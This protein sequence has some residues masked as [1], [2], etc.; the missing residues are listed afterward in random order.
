MSRKTS[1]LQAWAV[2]IVVAVGQEGAAGE[3]MSKTSAGVS[4]GLSFDPMAR[5]DPTK[6]AIL[7]FLEVR[8]EKRTEVGFVHMEGVNRLGQA[9]GISAKVTARCLGFGG[10]QGPTGDYDPPGWA[11][12][13][14]M[15]RLTLFPYRMGGYG[16]YRQG[17]VA[18]YR[19]TVVPKFEAVV[20]RL[21]A[22]MKDG[23]AVEF[24][25]TPVY[26][27]GPQPSA[28]VIR[29][30]VP[31]TDG[32]AKEVTIANERAPAPPVQPR[33]PGEL[34]EVTR[35]KR[36]LK[37]PKAPRFVGT[38]EAWTALE[39]QLGLTFPEDYGQFV[40]TY[41][42]GAIGSADFADVFRIATPF[43]AREGN[44]FEKVMKAR[45]E[46]YREERHRAPAATPGPPWPEA[47]GLLPFGSTSNGDVL[48]WRTRGAPAAWTV[49]IQ[50]RGGDMF[51]DSGCN[52]A[53]FLSR[54]IEEEFQARFL[55]PS[56]LR[57]PVF[58]PAP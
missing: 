39:K 38:P 10:Q 7:C 21:Y 4:V 9:T 37:P 43:S 40:A 32:G 23:A 30:D 55:L 17:L 58:A 45:L 41:G 3:P 25:I 33:Q 46:L 29:A 34:P 26:R 48:Y 47:G 49:V 16:D 14:G 57:R 20:D 54:A 35:L 13:Q 42:D 22:G 2:T 27:D 6:E 44:N 18:V 8:D 50:E 24:S 53:T 31:L 52:L 19:A 51:F 12:D 5:K 1:A 28:L 36:L 11:Y 56:Y 15:T